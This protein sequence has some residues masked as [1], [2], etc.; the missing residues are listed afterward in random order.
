MKRNAKNVVTTLVIVKNQND[1]ENRAAT[2]YMIIL[3]SEDDV[4]WV[5][6]GWRRQLGY[7]L[8]RHCGAFGS[9]FD[10]ISLGTLRMVLHK[11]DSIHWIS[12]GQSFNQTILGIL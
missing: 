7:A 5:L 10:R 9:A 2:A 3:H 4:R 8:G 6:V 1:D 11:D 12:L